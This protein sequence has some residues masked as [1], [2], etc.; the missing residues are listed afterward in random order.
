MWQHVSFYADNK[1]ELNLIHAQNFS[2]SGTS[3]VP[4]FNVL[5]SS[6]VLDIVLVLHPEGQPKA[7]VPA[8]RAKDPKKNQTILHWTLLLVQ[9]F[10]RN[11]LMTGRCS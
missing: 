10:I 1:V 9:A 5:C 11:L 6:L 3:Q 2:T 7:L 4:C 8:Q